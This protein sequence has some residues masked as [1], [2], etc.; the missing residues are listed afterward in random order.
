MNFAIR[1]LRSL[2]RNFFSLVQLL[3]KSE[4]FNEFAFFFSFNATHDIL[5]EKIKFEK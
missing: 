5:D 1:S 3:K 2:T 4:K